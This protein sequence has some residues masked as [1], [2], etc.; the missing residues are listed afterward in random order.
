MNAVSAN[1]DFCH[2]GCANWP[3]CQVLLVNQRTG[4]AS[5]HERHHFCCSACSRVKSNLA[6]QI[7]LGGVVFRA[8]LGS[9]LFR[10]SVSNGRIN[11]Q[12][13]Y[14]MDGPLA[15]RGFTFFGGVTKARSPSSPPDPLEI[16]VPGAISHHPGG[17]VSDPRP[18]CSGSKTPIG[19]CPVGAMA[20]RFESSPKRAESIFPAASGGCA[21]FVFP[22]LFFFFSSC[23]AVAFNYPNNSPSRVSCASTPSRTEILD[24]IEFRPCS[25]KC[26]RS[27]LRF[28]HHRREACTG[29]SIVAG[30]VH[31]FLLFL[32]EFYEFV[33]WRRFLL[34]VAGAFLAFFCNL[35]RT[36]LLVYVGAVRGS[37]TIKSWHD[38]AGHTILMACLLAL[39]G[40]SMF[41]RGKD[42][43]APQASRSRQ[44]PRATPDPRLSPRGDRHCRSGHPTLVSRP[45][46]T[47]SSTR[48]VDHR[49]A[50][51][52]HE[53][54]NGA[55][56]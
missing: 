40:L 23:R 34:V 14:G 46:I 39:W 19:G 21:H 42:R 24:L 50:V 10:A 49:M 32:G 47:D 29:H 7:V 31:G 13:G 26:D 30:H 35:V 56:R 3:G 20:L 17:R 8:R 27:R 5:S 2:P 22:I 16:I 41:L 15:L 48:T 38:P 52:S 1:V 37:D 33:V 12:Y 53:L 25:F 36:F 54:E 4:R 55:N 18:P 43:A 11:P 45:R 6:G 51:S 44:T 28:L 9:N